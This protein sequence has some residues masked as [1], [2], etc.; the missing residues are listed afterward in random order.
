ML[1]KKVEFK[2]NGKGNFTS[3]FG[4]SLSL[5]IYIG[6]LSLCWYFGKDIVNKDD[7]SQN[8]FTKFLA[9]YPYITIDKDNFA[10][11]FAVYDSHDN[12][13]NDPRAYTISSS[14]RQRKYD[15]DTDKTN[16]KSSPNVITDCNSLY[17]ISHYDSDALFS[18]FGSDCPSLDIKFGGNENEDGSIFP[19]V[20]FKRCSKADE[21]LNNFKCYT[22]EELINKFGTYLVV[23]YEIQNN[24]YRPNNL[25]T[26]L[27]T[28][29]NE[30]YVSLELISFYLELKIITRG[31]I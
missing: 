30:K 6:T 10:F 25:S 15:K 4:F 9:N 11:G 17:N 13:V 20:N 18:L 19:R 23:Y 22:D 28:T 14:I 29:F 3:G 2:V 27:V 24:Y 31:S 7:P 21:L 26:P 5:L 8:N 16:V 12:R 1:G